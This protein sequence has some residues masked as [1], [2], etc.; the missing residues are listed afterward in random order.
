MNKFRKNTRKGN[1]EVSTASLP[2]IIFILLFF[3]MVVTVLRQND[4]KVN[5]KLPEA[6]QLDKLDKEDKITIYIGKSKFSN[7]DKPVIQINDAFAEVSDIY[8]FLKMTSGGLP[9]KLNTVLK[10]DS[11][12]TMGIISDVKTEIRKADQLRISYATMTKNL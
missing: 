10:V 5:F 2:D 1:P 3:F 12:V 9:N 4:V 7:S 6:S 11:E 8:P